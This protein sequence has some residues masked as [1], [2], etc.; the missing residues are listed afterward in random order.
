MKLSLVIPARNESANIRATVEAV[1]GKLE[2]EQIPYELLVVDDGSGDAT[3][4]EV[5]RCREKNSSIVLIENEGPHGFG[6]A[7]R[8]GLAA[9]QG[10]AVVIMMADGSDDPGDLVR[11]YYILR[12]KAEC[13]FGS[14]WVRGG[15]VED[16][17]H[18]KRLL[19]RVSNRIIQ[20]MFGITY[21][22]VTNAFKGYRREVIEG[23][24]PLLSPHFNLTVELP[25]KAIVRGYSFEVIP[26]SWRA[27][28]KG[29]SL[30]KIDEMGSRYLY[31]ILNIWLERLLTRGD[32]H[33]KDKKD[34]PRHLK[35]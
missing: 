26:I 12:D 8:K 28:K 18:F 17:P 3:V 1:S 23:C 16:Y 10:D 6:N 5:E 31:I 29:D 33:R 7:V 11:Y 13:A 9:F 34:A 2:R 32:Y 21:S 19:N 20:L 14:R 35:A 25:L 30:F 22:D 24:Q 4:E 15:T 27:R